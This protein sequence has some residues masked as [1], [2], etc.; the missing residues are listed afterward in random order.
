MPHIIAF[1]AQ[2]KFIMLPANLFASAGISDRTGYR[3]IAFLKQN[4]IVGFAGPKQK[5]IYVLK[6]IAKQ[7]LFP[8]MK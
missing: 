4:K 1:R 6:Y 7:K 8:E 2:L 5:G 3:H